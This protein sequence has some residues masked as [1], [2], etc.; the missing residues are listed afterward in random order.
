MMRLT[1]ALLVGFAAAIAVAVGMG[2]AIGTG[3]VVGYGAGAGLA[4][5]GSLLQAHTLARRSERFLS[6]LAVAFLAKLA[7]LFLGAL[8]FRFIPAAAER[9]DWRG[10]VVAFGAAVA[11]V[12]P[13]GTMDAARALRARAVSSATHAA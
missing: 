13:F 5:L 3:V 4:A 11:L 12:L 1:I 9:V 8:A 2:G 6:V 7:V 10:F